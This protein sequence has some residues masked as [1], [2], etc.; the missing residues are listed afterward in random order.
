M[1]GRWIVSVSLLVLLAA[2]GSNQE[3]ASDPAVK[4]EA[5]FAVKEEGAG[6]FIL[7]TTTSTKFR[8]TGCHSTRFRKQNEHHGRS[9]R[10][11]HGTSVESG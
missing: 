2:C 8:L 3:L 7:A 4:K 6:Q 11:R 5:S 9:G 10:R 1:K